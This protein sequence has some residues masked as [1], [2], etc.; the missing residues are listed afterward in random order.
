MLLQH[1][2]DPSTLKVARRSS[3]LELKGRSAG[4]RGKVSDDFII[5]SEDAGSAR[6]TMRPM[7]LPSLRS[8]SACEASVMGRITSGRDLIVPVETIA[9]NSYGSIFRCLFVWVAENP[10]DTFVKKREEETLN[11]SREPR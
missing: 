4:T 8:E 10:V 1:A 5:Q 2:W 6:R 7:T 11:S 3:A 9:I